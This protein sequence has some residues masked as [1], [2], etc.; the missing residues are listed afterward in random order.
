[1]VA[2]QRARAAGA[3]IVLLAAPLL[4]LATIASCGPNADDYPY[5]R[6]DAGYPDGLPPED[7]GPSNIIEDDP[8]EDWD[9]TGAGPLSGIFAVELTIKANV[10]VEVESRQLA[11]FRLLQRGREVRMRTQ[12]CR[13]ALPSVA[14]VVDLT[15]PLALEML[16]RSKA[17]EHLGDY[18]S[19]D[20]PV[21]ARFEPPDLFSLIG[22]E[23]DD[24]RN[25]PLPTQANPLSALDEDD[26]G[27][28][29]VTV[30][31][32]TLLCAQ[33]ESVFVALRTVGTMSGTVHSADSFDG[34]LEPVLEQSVLGYSHDCMAT[35]AALDIEILPGSSFRAVRLGDSFDIDENG[36]ITCGEIVEA[37]AELFGAYWADRN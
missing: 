21:G 37:A 26:D 16:L 20:D 23:L 2:R 12:T 7:A 9:T 14:G 25:D 22:A 5:L 24:P 15:I 6:P 13:L 33:Q 29:G 34:T 3:A 27:H 10:I 31:A 19:A 17:E 4:A 1:M 35:A 8:L 30:Y 36:N 32:D 11:R 28:P 18:L